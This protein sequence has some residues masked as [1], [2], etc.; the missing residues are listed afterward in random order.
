M[1]LVTYVSVLITVIAAPLGVL[2]ATVASE[3]VEH[4]ADTQFQQSEFDADR[5]LLRFDVRDNGTA[6]GRVEYR[7]ALNGTNRSAFTQL[8]RDIT[9]NQTAYLDRF[10][11]RVTQTVWTTENTTDRPMDVTNASVRAETRQL[12]QPHGIVVYTFTWHGFAAEENGE[13][14]MGNAL[15]GLFLDEEMQ[16]QISWP[17][18]Y[19]AQTVHDASEQRDHAAIWRGPMWFDQEGPR[20]VL[21]Q[22]G[23]QIDPMP[24]ALLALSMLFAISGG[25]FWWRADRSETEQTTTPDSRG[26]QPANHDHG[27]HP[28]NP[29]GGQSPEST[30][31]EPDVDPELMSN[32]ERILWEITQRGGRVKQQELIAVL[33]WSD[34]KVSRSVSALRERGAIERFR[35]GNENVLSVAEN[36]DEEES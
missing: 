5:V 18:G 4:S 33:E 1:Q 12:P 23:P 16:L 11:R 20:V 31:F 17:D 28:A 36:G 8:Q 34:A 6:V 29:D 13:L 32:E 7:F 14:R 30:T 22:D 25:V 10:E 2:G 21:D 24:V 35:I 15:A 9:S 3:D 27:S 19:Q 26:Q